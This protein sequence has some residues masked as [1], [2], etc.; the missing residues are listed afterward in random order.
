MNVVFLCIGAA[1]AGTDWLHQQLA[2]HPEC[3]LRAIKELH[4]F[5]ALEAGHLKQEL[6]KHRDLQEALLRRLAQTGDAPNDDQAARLADRADWMDVLERGEDLPAYLAY[7]AEG[8]REG[9]VVADMTPAYALLPEARLDAMA[10]MAGDVRFL[11]L[12]RD[13]IERLWSHV[14]MIA[15]RRDPEGRIRR[16]RCA[17]I[18]NR[19][20]SGA[21]EQIAK[22]SDYA[23]TLKRLASAVPGPQL[24]VEAFENMVAGEGLLRL[25][26]FLGIAPMAADA[27]PVHRGQPLEMT[28]DQ[29]QA[30]ATW[31]APQY[32]AAEVALGGLPQGW[33]R[34]G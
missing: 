29:R 32:D 12:L 2:R 27:A 34:E 17:R 8:A 10:R 18:L 4:Y 9:Q 3:H 11:Y 23:A 13:P 22:R 20:F 33:R 6:T 28:R 7:L 21:E 31:L 1:K 24:L 30:A 26:A 19:V 16:E 25:C 5:D 14:R 15:V